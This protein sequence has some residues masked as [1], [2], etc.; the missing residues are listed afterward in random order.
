M[1]T[2]PIKDILKNEKENILK[3]TPNIETNKNL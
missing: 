1:T 2:I 3:T